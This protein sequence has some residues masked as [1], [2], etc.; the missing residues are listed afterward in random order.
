MEQTQVIDHGRSPSECHAFQVHVGSMRPTS[1]GHI[2]LA[3]KDPK[4]D[5]I[6]EPNYLETGINYFYKNLAFLLLRILEVESR[7]DG[8]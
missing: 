1:R 3:A 8:L 7:L 4:I 6:I 5:P 2:R